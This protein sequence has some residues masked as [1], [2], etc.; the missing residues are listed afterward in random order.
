M[1]P[2]F[3]WL[4]DLHE[5]AGTNLQ[6]GHKWVFVDNCVPGALEE[7]IISTVV[8]ASFSWSCITTARLCL[9]LAW[10]TGRRRNKA[11]SRTVSASSSSPR[12]DWSLN[13]QNNA[14][15]GWNN[16][17]K[18]EFAFCLSSTSPT[19]LHS[20]NLTAVPHC[21]AR[22][23]AAPR[24]TRWHQPDFWEKKKLWAQTNPRERQTENKVTA[25]TQAVLNITKPPAARTTQL[26]TSTWKRWW[27]FLGPY[28]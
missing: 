19:W 21:S 20:S 13:W 9:S 1:Q 3:I 17:E 6:T 22:I 18:L 16:S 14:C 15:A 11:E 4:P 26:S 24:R 7:S 28:G 23:P 8:W 12:S 5:P 2:V 27:L 25:E 10:L